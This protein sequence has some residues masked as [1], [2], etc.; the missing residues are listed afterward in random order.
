MPQSLRN[1]TNHLGLKLTDASETSMTF[2]E[3][4]TLM[5]G[6]DGNSNMELID[7]AIE[8]IDDK[9]EDLADNEVIQEIRGSA[10]AVP[11][12]N[13]SSR[14]LTF[15]NLDGEPIGD[16]IVISG[17]GGGGGGGGYGSVMRLA[18]RSPR[19][20][21]ITYKDTTMPILYTVTSVE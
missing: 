1:T 4:R 10:I 17:G 15:T 21:A 8:D 13:E 11:E 12:W 14:E 20:I 9:I 6:T 3:W 16:P 18:S 5:N 19:S 7:K 2:L